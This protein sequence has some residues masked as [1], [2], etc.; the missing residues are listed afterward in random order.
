MTTGAVVIRAP[1]FYRD[2]RCRYRLR[3][4]LRCSAASAMAPKSAAIML[5]AI[6]AS[7]Q[8]T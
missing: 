1:S 6:I 8:S 2:R 4:A 7:T 5:A 3:S